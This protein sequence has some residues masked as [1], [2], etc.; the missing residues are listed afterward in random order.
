MRFVWIVLLAGCYQNPALDSACKVRCTTSCP[1]GASCVNGYCVG[2]GQAC[3]GD[4]GIDAATTTAATPCAVEIAHG[5]RHSCMRKPNGT[6]WCS[7]RGSTGALGTGQ[8]ETD[9]ATAVQAV[10]ANGPITDAT[11]VGV[12]RTHSCAVR[13]GG[14][15]WCWGEGANGQLGHNMYADSPLAVRVVVAGGGPLTN[16]VEV[17]GGEDF[18]CA[19]DSAGG[20]WCWGLGNQGQ[21]GD[22]TSGHPYAAAVLDPSF[23]PFTDVA[24]IDAASDHACLRTNTNEAWCWGRNDVGQLGDTTATNRYIPVRPLTNVSAIATGR[25]HTCA[26]TLSSTVNCWG[27]YWQQRLGDGG[28]VSLYAPTGFVLTMA[29]GSQ[30]TGATA[31]A[32]GGFSCVVG[33][34]GT[35]QCWG[36]SPH[37][38]TGGGGG[39]FPRPITLENGAPL[40]NVD[41]IVGGYS[42]VCAHRN[43]G[44]WLC[45]GRNGAGELGLGTFDNL[46][47][48]TPLKLSCP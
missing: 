37:G 23:A 24:D 41:R 48:A 21:L 9:V 38:Q 17:D 47:T 14:E 26:I 35:V 31:I 3:A 1:A 29:N 10:D 5:R 2:A 34:G 11:G 36:N 27:Y 43:D 33:A 45:W 7:G 18:T 6:V 15:V 40:T 46:A 8:V 19:R 25:Y 12:G 28:A 32:V 4:A 13:A 39:A 44:I 16:V 42:K 22:N 20:A 30:L